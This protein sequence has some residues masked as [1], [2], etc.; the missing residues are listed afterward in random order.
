MR[1]SGQEDS[2]ARRPGTMRKVCLTSCA[3]L[4]ATSETRL[5]TSLSPGVSA[6]SVSQSAARSCRCV[7]KIART[8][9]CRR[10][11]TTSRARYNPS[12]GLVLALDAAEGAQCDGLA[13][14]VVPGQEAETLAARLAAS[15]RAPGFRPYQSTDLIG[16]ELGGAVKN[17]IAIACGMMTGAGFA[18]NTRA[19]LITRGLVEISRLGVELGGIRPGVVEDDAAVLEADVGR[20]LQNDRCERRA[21]VHVCGVGHQVAVDVAGRQ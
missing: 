12:P 19:A 10:T 2:A 21:A 6:L 17:V 18:E 15:L 4:S 9:I 14:R 3:P 20:E 1:Q 7:A 5:I 8:P 11:R 13:F 16:V